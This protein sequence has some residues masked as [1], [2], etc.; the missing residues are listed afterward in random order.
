MEARASISVTESKIG[1]VIW[2]INSVVYDFG[3]W[4]VIW[5]KNVVIMIIIAV[6]V[7]VICSS[8]SNTALVVSTGVW[9]AKKTRGRT[10]STVVV[11]ITMEFITN[12]VIDT[13][14]NIVDVYCNI[15]R[16]VRLSVIA[17]VIRLMSDNCSINW[18]VSCSGF[19]LSLVDD[20]FLISEGSLI[21][22]HGD[23]SRGS[24][25]NSAIFG[26]LD[27]VESGFRLGSVLSLELDTE[28]GVEDGFVPDLLFCSV[29]DLVLSGEPSFFLVEIDSLSIGSFQD[30]DLMSVSVLFLLSVE[31]FVARFIDDVWNVSVVGLGVGVIDESWHKLIL[32]EVV[33]LILHLVVCGESLFFVR[34][35]PGLCL[36]VDVRQRDLSGPDLGLDLGIDSV[37]DFFVLNWDIAEFVGLTVFLVG[38]FVFFAISSDLEG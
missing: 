5:V 21:S 15:L 18:N 37:L 35:V 24:G 11:T 17:R 16:F 36:D 14:V 2:I 20:I 22:D 25:G 30:L 33:W 26:L 32:G 4:A 31:N 10:M 23:L 34:L 8:G 6:S 7:S 28:V 3:V 38:V 13:R 19:V 12:M 9:G 1:S 29:E 27:S